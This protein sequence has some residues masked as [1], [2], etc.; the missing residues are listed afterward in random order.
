MTSGNW[1]LWLTNLSD[2]WSLPGSLIRCW[3]STIMAIFAPCLSD[4]SI[5][6]ETAKQSIQKLMMLVNG[7]LIDQINALNREGGMLSDP[8]IWDGRLAQE[9]RHGWPEMNATL[10]RA[11]AQLEESST[12]GK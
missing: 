5:S 12:E 3:K 4:F 11:K 1:L 7:P 6:T 9:F 8:D 2:T 10:L